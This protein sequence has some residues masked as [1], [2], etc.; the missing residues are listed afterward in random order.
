VKTLKGRYSLPAEIANFDSYDLQ[1]L[2]TV[3]ARWLDL[4]AQ[5]RYTRLRTGKVIVRFHLHSDGRITG[6][7][8]LNNQV[9]ETQGLVCQK[10]VLDPAPYARRPQASG[11]PEHPDPREFLLT[12]SYQ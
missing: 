7:D 4:L 5:W 2:K 11:A 9:G 3:E 10:A 8:R 6:L 12:F 1:F